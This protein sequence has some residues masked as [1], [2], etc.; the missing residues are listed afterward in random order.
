MK[1]I[2]AVEAKAKSFKA[3]M[4]VC[5]YL[6]FNQIW[7]KVYLPFHTTLFTILCTNLAYSG[8]GYENLAYLDFSIKDK[9][10]DPNNLNT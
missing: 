10:V 9:T 7:E 4:T 1:G 3:R 8:F 6:I 2:E 5:S